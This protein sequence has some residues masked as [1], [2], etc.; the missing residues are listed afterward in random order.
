[1][2][3]QF[4]GIIF[5]MDGTMIDNMMVH[6]HAWK[7]KLSS[8]GLEMSLEE[9]MEKVHG[10]NEEIIARLFG[11]RFTP[12]ERKKISAEKEAE[13]R[14]IFLPQL[15]LIEGLAECL[16]KLVARE[17]PMAVGT[18]A[19]PGNVEFVVDNLQLA[20]YFKGIF[21]SRSVKKGKPDPEIFEMAAG[22]MGLQAKDCLVFEDSLT[23]VETALNAGAKVVVVT[24]THQEE[25]FEHFSNILFYIKNYNDPQLQQLLSN[26]FS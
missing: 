1:M 13:Y 2:S 26:H 23:G 3:K 21:H 8:L 15:K 16:D 6:H 12:E 24:T 25:E 5:D 7:R 22:S 4:K 19:P 9:I 20:P 14:K 18:A 17:I 10:I 11:D